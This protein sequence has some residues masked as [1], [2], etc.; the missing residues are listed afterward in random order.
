M[1]ATKSTDI[2]II[3]ATVYFLPITLRVPLK[4]GPETVTNAECLR[5]QIEVEDRRGNRGSGWGETPLSVS[6][7]WP[8]QLSVTARMER[9]REFSL[10]LAGI[11][12]SHPAVHDRDR[13][14]PA[15]PGYGCSSL[16]APQDR[17]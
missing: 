3:G 12:A 14:D 4:F 11:L 8:S 10:R 6:W 17:A 7:V 5:V 9:M 16:A 2:R 13:Q 15:A 1:S